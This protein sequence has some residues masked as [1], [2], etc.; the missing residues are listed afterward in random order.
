VKQDKL[1]GRVELARGRKQL[2]EAHKIV[3]KLGSLDVELSALMKNKVI[4]QLPAA[5]VKPALDITEQVSCM[6]AEANKY[7]AK[8]GELNHTCT[9][10]VDA[11]KIANVQKVFISSLLTAAENAR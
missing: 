8:G 2:M 5:F 7:I 6:L 3:T 11:W 10:A 9:D 4:K 1:A